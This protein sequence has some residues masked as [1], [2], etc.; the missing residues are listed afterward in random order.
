MQGEGTG[1]NG[2]GMS[3]REIAEELGISRQR[4]DQI[5]A[6]ALAKCKVI[7]EE[8]DTDWEDLVPYL[9]KEEP[10]LIP[11]TLNSPEPSNS[12]E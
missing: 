6:E 3:S 7:L 10:W 12:T 11:F 8:S 2:L 1:Y 5:V 4:V 9:A